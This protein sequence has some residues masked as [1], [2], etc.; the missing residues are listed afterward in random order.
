MDQSILLSERASYPR[1]RSR[2]NVPSRY[3]AGQ[4]LIELYVHFKLQTQWLRCI[5]SQRTSRIAERAAYIRLASL[6]TV[7]SAPSLGET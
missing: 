3:L 7:L 6:S 4:A 5:L 1:P 2:C